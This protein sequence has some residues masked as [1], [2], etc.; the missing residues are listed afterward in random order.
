MIR[1]LALPAIAACAL[2]VAP[3]AAQAPVSITGAVTD[4]SGR[5]LPGAAIEARRGLRMVA[6]A[7]TRPDGGYRLDLPSEGPIA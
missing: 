3:A 6:S 5:V 1:S 2:A 4:A 7:T